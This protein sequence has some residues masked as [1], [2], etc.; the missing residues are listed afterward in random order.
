MKVSGPSES[1]KTTMGRCRVFGSVLADDNLITSVLAFLL[2]L[3]HKCCE[4]GWEPVVRLR[5]PRDLLHMRSDKGGGGGWGGR[6]S[7]AG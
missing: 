6:L 1:L 4:L 2:D 3:L 7:L 5:D